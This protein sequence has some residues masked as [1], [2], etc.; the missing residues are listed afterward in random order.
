MLHWDWLLLVGNEVQCKGEAPAKRWCNSILYDMWGPWR[1]GENC[2]DCM[3]SLRNVFLL[4]RVDR[5][6]GYIVASSDLDPDERGESVRK[7]LIIASNDI[8]DAFL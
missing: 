6:E 4:L 5:K 8:P 1:L 7:L 2:Y 3:I